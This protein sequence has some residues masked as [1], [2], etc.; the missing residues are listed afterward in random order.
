M[1]GRGWRATVSVLLVLGFQLVAAT[2]ARADEVTEACAYALRELSVV[3]GG[4]YRGAPETFEDAGQIYRGCVVTV[5]GDQR[6]GPDTGPPADRLY[7]TPGSAAAKAGW[8]ADRE[9][10]GPDGTAYRI[11]RGRVF[12]LVN[13]AWDGGDDSDPTVV[14]SPLFLI[15]VRCA[16][17]R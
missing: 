14:P 10:D 3:P 4:L 9:A 16:R 8:K 1:K 11:S 2:L 15:T 5:V 7:P 17:T 13:G 6:R 12:C